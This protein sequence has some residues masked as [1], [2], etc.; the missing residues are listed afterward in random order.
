M[1][2][3]IAAVL[4]PVTALALI[5]T[6]V[7]GYQENQEKNSL[8]IKAENQYQRAFHDLNFHM[9]QLQ[10]EL[11][12]ALALNTRKQM[13]TC[14]TNV[15]RLTYASQNDLGQLPLSMMPFDKTQ[16]FLSKI[17]DFTY[18]VGVRD[19]N[20]EPLTDREYN[21][22]RS[23]YE[24]SNTIQRDLSKVQTQVLNNNL[25]WMDTEL[26]MASEDKATNNTI[27]NGFKNVD[28][29]SEGYR[30][31]D[32]GPSVNNLESEQRK[33]ADALKGE[34]VTARE[35][36][37]KIADVLDLQNTNGIHVVRNA[38]GDTATYSVR[39][40]KKN[41]TEV[42]ADVSRKGGYILWLNYDRN[43]KDRK[44]S[45]EQAQGEAVNYLDRLGFPEM[46]T[47]KYDDVGNIASFTF[48]RK[49]DD[50]LIYPETVVVKVAL[51]NGEIF[52]Y[53]GDD[54]VFNHKEKRNMKPKLSRAE[55]KKSVSPRLKLEESQLAVIFGDRGKEVLCHEFTGRLGKSKYRVFI[56]ADNGDEEF[57]EKVKE[58]DTNEI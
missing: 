18:R 51:D 46:E 8:M 36:K 25:R 9:D 58:Q 55:A 57:V 20:K 31:V 2:R 48:V 33:K 43:V 49:Q 7:W 24:K 10:D 54:Y 3:R 11:G 22:L 32:W 34:P 12:K 21:T 13:S 19:L 53:Q 27:I 15:W 40:E 44:L 4:F 52:G 16:S 37:D 23:L 17:G 35:V 42:N 45:M 38:K 5:G 26:A 14:M 28:K 56:N 30:E 39:V 6:A 1:Y 47:I 50:V 29:L 41:G